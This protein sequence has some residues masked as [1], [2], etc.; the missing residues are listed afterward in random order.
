MNELKKY[1]CFV[2]DTELYLWESR[3]YAKK[4]KQKEN[5]IMV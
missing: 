4:T 3:I 5:Q 2:D 1:E